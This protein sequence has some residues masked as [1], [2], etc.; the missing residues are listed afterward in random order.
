M[1][2]IGGFAA[3]AICT[4]ALIIAPVAHG[5]QGSSS[6]SRWEGLSYTADPGEANRLIAEDWLGSGLHL[7]DRG[8]VIRWTAIPGVSTC[9]GAVHDVWCT[10]GYGFAMHADLGDGADTYTSTSGWLPGTIQL[11]AGPDTAVGGGGGQTIDGGPGNDVIR[12]G[13]SEP[14]LNGGPFPEILTGG[15][16]KD[17]LRADSGAPG[18]TYFQAR[19]GER[20]RIWCG[21]G[22]DGVEADA[23]DVIE[24]P[25]ACESVLLG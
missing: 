13:G 18:E 4:A 6:V 16:G 12:G 11:G 7:N 14:N 5:A 9:Q 22:E 23:L 20:D 19:D 10:G 17:T 24:T 21:A 1:T 15:P 25:G 8:A 3:A 2:R